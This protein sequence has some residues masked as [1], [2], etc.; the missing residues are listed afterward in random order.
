MVA[1]TYGG[2]RVAGV[3]STAKEVAKPVAQTVAIAPRKAWYARLVDAMIEARM[4]QARREIRM[5]TEL[6]PYTVDDKGNRI[7]KADV[8]SPVGGW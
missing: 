1:L 6:M 4:Q 7:L 8:N 3:E 2:A 5:Y